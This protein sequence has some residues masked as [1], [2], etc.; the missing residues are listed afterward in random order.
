[1]YKTC[2]IVDQIGSPIRRNHKQRETL[3]FREY[4]VDRISWNDELIRMIE[5]HIE[6]EKEGGEYELYWIARAIQL[7]VLKQKLLESLKK[8]K[9][10]NFWAANA[11]A[12]YW[13]KADSD[14]SEIF[15]EK[16]RG[17]PTDIASI[18]GSIHLMV[19]EKEEARKALIRALKA[20]S[21]RDG[22]LV[23]GLRKLGILETDEECFQ[24]CLNAARSRAPAH[25]DEWR[26]EMILLF[27]ARQAVRE[28]ALEEISR[29]DGEIGA[30]AKSYKHDVDMCSRLIKIL[31]PLNTDARSIL[32]GGLQSTA[33]S[34]PRALRLLHAARQD[35]DGTISTPHRRPQSASIVEAA[36]HLADTVQIAP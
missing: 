31:A 12:E 25:E 22:F 1:M 24:A 20:G 33:G 9:W 19:D 27:P 7:P 23:R 26:R 17:S 4:P 3:V 34:S 2:L 5:R 30:V 13:G 6:K 18:A 21:E 29:R 32:V 11:L 10:L 8:T 16:I 36:T 15:N 35:T 28:I 14:V